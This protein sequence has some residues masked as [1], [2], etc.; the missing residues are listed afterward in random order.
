[1]R[2]TIFGAT[3]KTGLHLVEQAVG[4][5][6]TVTA[7]VRDPGRFGLR[8]AGLTVVRVGDP[9]RDAD[10][11]GKAM[12]GAD[13]VLSAVG[14]RGRNVGPVAAP[15]TRALLRGLDRVPSR[16]I[17]VIS[18]AP[19]GPTPD[20]DSLLSR[21]V[22][23]PVISAVLRPV[24]DDLRAM[25]EALAASGAAWT[26]VRPPQLT[27]GPLRGGYR[28]TVGGVVPRGYRVSR[29]DLA[30][31]MLA[32]LDRPETIGQPVGVAD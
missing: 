8:H 18:A 23:R 27:D 7:V 19:V 1:M 5:G 25:E 12:D 20:G 3:G 17:V 24:Y 28:T 26:S 29:A 10:E 14:P 22:L 11:V 2:L 13:A 16:R 31:A 4:R 32:C 6:D 9:D 30:H 15:V 21:A